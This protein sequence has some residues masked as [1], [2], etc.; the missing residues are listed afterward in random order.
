MKTIG[1]GLPLKRESLLEALVSGF[2]A[3]ALLALADNPHMTRH[4]I[5]KSRQALSKILT[6]QDTTSPGE[7]TIPCQS[8]A[9]FKIA[10]GNYSQA[11][12][13]YAWSSGYNMGYIQATKDLLDRKSQ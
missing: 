5:Y 13:P 2:I 6:P 9:N 8:G 4:M 10:T 1:V 12:D 7:T 3:G 11:D